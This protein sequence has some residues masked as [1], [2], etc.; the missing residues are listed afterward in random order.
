[1]K[2]IPNDARRIGGTVQ[3]GLVTFGLITVSAVSVVLSPTNANALLPEVSVDVPTGKLLSPVT[4]TVS[5][6]TGALNVP[7]TVDSTP[8][9]LGAD[10]S[11]PTP[12]RQSE[13]APVQASVDVTLPRVVPAVT[14]TVSDVVQPEKT[15]APVLQPVRDIIAPQ[16]KSQP[17]PPSN[18]P[19]NQQPEYAAANQPQSSTP[20]IIPAS[21]QMDKVANQYSPA[22]TSKSV[23]ATLGASPSFASVVAGAASMFSLSLPET[24]QNLAQVAAFGGVDTLPFIISSIIFIITILLIAGILYASNR[25]RLFST[26]GRFGRLALRYDLAQLSIIT[27]ATVGTGIIA[28]YMLFIYVIK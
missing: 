12:S 1:M 8:R 11:L 16:S 17:Q 9:N 15:I 20:S 6:V 27:V 26:D 25:T 18:Q 10:V 24:L 13:S 4:D 23:N 5:D 2:V 14:D 19:N 21:A 3:V 7:V 28:V 22:S